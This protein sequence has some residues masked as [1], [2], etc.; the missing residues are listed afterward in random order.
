MASANEELSSLFSLTLTNLNLNLY[1]CR[2]SVLE[3]RGYD[4]SPAS[5]INSSVWLWASVFPSP[6]SVSDSVK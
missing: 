6:G 2:A 4:S 3:S 5:D 1:K